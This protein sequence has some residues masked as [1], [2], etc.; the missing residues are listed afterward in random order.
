MIDSALLDTLKR[1][2]VFKTVRTLAQEGNTSV[3]L[4]G[5]A[6]RDLLMGALPEKDFDFATQHD[7]V[8]MARRFAHKVSGTFIVL[9]EEPPNYRIVFYRKHRRIEVDFSAFR[10]LDLHEDLKLRDF[11]VNAMAIAVSDLY[12]SGET[13]IFDPTGGIADLQS[14]KVRA[15]SNRAFHDDPLR[16]LRAVRIA[17]AW[18]LRID[19]ATEKE[20]T[21][22]RELLGTVATERI[23]SE[24]CKAIAYSDAPATIQALDR[25]GLLALLF[26]DS[27]LLS[28]RSASNLFPPDADLRATAQ[29]EWA[30]ANLRTFCQDFE[31][32]VNGHVAQE[33]EADMYY[34]TL[35]KLGGIV[36][37]LAQGS[38]QRSGAQMQNASQIGISISKR[39]R[40]GK[41]ATKILHTMVERVDRVF[42]ML[43][44]DPVPE[45]TCF[46]Y[47][48]DFGSQGIELLI[49]AWAI[50]S[51]Y[52]SNNYPPNFETKL[53]ILAHRLLYYYYAEFCTNN[54]QP[55]LSGNDL[56]TRFGLK[57]GKVVGTVLDRIGEAE[58]QGRLRSRKEALD[59][60]QKFL[61]KNK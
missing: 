13:P 31:K 18:G 16:I 56:I 23:R 10:G 11:T 5:G 50:S 1:L 32:N 55:L 20:I 22:K 41:T 3:Y 47:F 17:K 6:V 25:L 36:V 46:R 2:E 33:V 60:V 9:S 21:S 59:F 39:L 14:K 15:T 27:F 34:T 8:P 35:L 53:R 7:P 19:S 30:L 52:D 61:S 54:P 51:A 28:E 40:F 48:Y 24:F 58:A 49:H 42:D 43:R 38:K 37:D 26:G 4:V 29:T 44:M 45:R 12:E 57:E